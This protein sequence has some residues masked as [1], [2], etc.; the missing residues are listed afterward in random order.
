MPPLTRRA[1]ARLDLTGATVPRQSPDGCGPNG[2]LARLD[3][4]GA[5][6]PRQSPDGWGPNGLLAR[7]RRT[8]ATILHQIGTERVCV[9]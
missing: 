1:L 2:L 4:T 3:L 6:V 9:A 8:G 5:T 7:L